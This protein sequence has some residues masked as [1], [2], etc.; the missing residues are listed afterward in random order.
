MNSQHFTPVI[1]IFVQRLPSFLFFP[2]PYAFR[3]LLNLWC[4][5][6]L[7]KLL[8]S[9]W[10]ILIGKSDFFPNLSLILRVPTQAFPIFSFFISHQL[11]NTA[12]LT[13]D[14]H[15]PQFTNWSCTIESFLHTHRIIL[16]LVCNLV[17]LHIFINLKRNPIL[18]SHRPP[19]LSQIFFPLIFKSSH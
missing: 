3:T 6:F 18:L 4:L 2:C 1:C 17:V 14:S 11:L 13:H 5:C 19:N 15:A 16:K 7:I 9:H 10:F 12:L 8:F